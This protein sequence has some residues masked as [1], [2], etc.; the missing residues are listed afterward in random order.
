[1]Q[2]GHGAGIENW[3]FQLFH[4]QMDQVFLY[5]SAGL[6][7]SF[8]LCPEGLLQPLFLLQVKLLPHLN[9]DFFQNLK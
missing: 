2:N 6:A 7:E 9:V 5:T 1:M 8:G 3:V 4:C